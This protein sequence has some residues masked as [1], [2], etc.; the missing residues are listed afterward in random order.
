MIFSWVPLTRFFGGVERVVVDSLLQIGKNLYAFI[1]RSLVFL[2]V[3]LDVP[4]V[5]V[6]ILI[7]GK[8]VYCA[9]ILIKSQKNEEKST[10]NNHYGV[11]VKVVV[12]LTVSLEGVVVSAAGSDGVT[13]GVP[14]VVVVESEVVVSG[15][16]VVGVSVMP[17]LVV[18]PET[19][20]L[21]PATVPV[22]PLVIVVVSVPMLL[23]LVAVS[24]EVLVP[25]STIAGVVGASTTSKVSR[26]KVS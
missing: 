23:E 4:V 21:S 9:N 5:P 18:S 6:K 24:L 12:A 8:T 7:P 15:V 10:G 22:L 16:V 1:G 14:S 11:A 2:P 17:V 26:P 19:V 3:F 13:V 25:L 20:V